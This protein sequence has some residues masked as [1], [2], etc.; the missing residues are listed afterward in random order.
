MVLVIGVIVVVG[1][2]FSGGF[3]GPVTIFGPVLKK[4]LM[5]IGPGLG[6]GGFGPAIVVLLK[7]KGKTG[8]IAQLKAATIV[9]IRMKVFIFI[10]I[11]SQYI[12]INIK[13]NKF[14]SIL[15][16]FFNYQ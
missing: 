16:V 2:G 9:K 10:F 1:K 15:I 12:I 8:A 4:S 13:S 11:D 5:D 6:F 14:L 7:K 3:D